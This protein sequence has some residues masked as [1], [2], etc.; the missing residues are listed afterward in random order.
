MNNIKKLLASAAALVLA[1]GVMAALAGCGGGGSKGPSDEELIKQNI[2]TYMEAFKDP[3]TAESQKILGDDIKSGLEQ[4]DQYGIDGLDFIKHCFSR[5]EYDVTDVKVNGDKATAK[6]TITNLDLT[7]LLNAAGEELQA[8]ADTDA[9]LNEL[10]GASD[11]MKAIYAK[12]FEMFYAQIDS[13]D[14]KTYGKTTEV[15]LNMVKKD[16]A[17]DIADTTDVNSFVSALYGGLDMSSL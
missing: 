12:M 17:W 5:V 2:S 6:V 16:G 4:F 8:W 10:M 13:A 11:P 14:M 3:T 9:G 15:T 1:F 7:A